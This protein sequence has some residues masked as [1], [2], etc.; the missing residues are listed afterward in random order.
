M[1]LHAIQGILV[2][3]TSRIHATTDK[4][5]VKVVLISVSESLLT[6]TTEKEPTSH[7]NELADKPY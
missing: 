4:Q 6:R 2:E 5:I 7:M 1:D 3:D